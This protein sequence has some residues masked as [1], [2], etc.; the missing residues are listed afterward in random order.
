MAFKDKYWKTGV[1]DFLAYKGK[2]YTPK[3]FAEELGLKEDDYVS[4]TS[5]T[6]HPF[7]ERFALEVPDN[8][9]MDQMY[10]LP[11]DEMMAVIDN[12]IA[13]GYTLAWGADV[14]EDGFTRNGIGVMPDAD[15]GAEITGSDMA[16]W[17]GLKADQRMDELTKRPLP[18]VEVT[19]PLGD[20]R[21]PRHADL[22]HCARPERQEI[23]HGEE[24]LG[25]GAFRL[26]GYMV[27]K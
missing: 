7:Y 2:K 11:I 20:N 24:L 1:E 17:L 22:R 16:H 13:K 25:N 23:L 4:I 10:N 26:Q 6:H 12:A 5:Y 8:W 21:R 19:Q 18:E 27:C 9:S 15:N 3:S 14:S